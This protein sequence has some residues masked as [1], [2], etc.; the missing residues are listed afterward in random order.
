MKLT[1]GTTN[2]PLW[3]GGGGRGGYNPHQESI[4]YFLTKVSK[5]LDEQLGNYD[6]IFI[7]GDFNASVSENHMKD[8]CVMYDLE[9]LISGP[10]CFK[11]ANNPSS[12]DVMLTNRKTSFQNSMTIETGLPDHHK[13]TVTVLK[14]YFKKKKPIKI[15]YRSYKYFNESEFRND[16]QKNLEIT[17]KESIQYDEFKHI[18]MKVLDWHAPK[19]TKTVRGNNAPFMNKVLS[20]AFM[21]RSKF[22]KSI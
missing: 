16:L 3:G 8:F 13:M 22:K 21:H 12:I 10:T 15:N 4:P 11:N 19:K 6:N 17:N 9:N 1:Y 2:G 18:F 5:E 20:N 7:L 14:T